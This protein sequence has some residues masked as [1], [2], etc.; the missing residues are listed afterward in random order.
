MPFAVS[1]AGFFRVFT[2]AFLFP[3]YIIIHAGHVHTVRLKRLNK[4]ARFCHTSM[5][6]WS[7][8]KV[9]IFEHFA[10]EYSNPTRTNPTLQL[11]Q[12]IN[13]LHWLWT[14]IVHVFSGWHHY[15]SAV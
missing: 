11:V 8:L 14:A 3:F 5:P 9:R 6:F 10:T 15:S 2:S 7:Y 12:S 13:R 1:I 4:F